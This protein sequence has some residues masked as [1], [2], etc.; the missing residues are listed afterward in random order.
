MSRQILP[1]AIDATTAFIVLCAVSI[2]LSKTG[3]LRTRQDTELFKLERPT[4]SR[5]NLSL[6]EEVLQS[7]LRA[8]YPAIPKDAI[9][10]LPE[11]NEFRSSIAAYCARSQLR[12]EQSEELDHR[13]QKYNVWTTWAM[14]GVMLFNIVLRSLQEGRE[15]SPAE[16]HDDDHTT[17]VWPATLLK[18]ELH[19]NG[20][21]GEIT[22]RRVAIKMAWRLALVLY[23]LPQL[24]ILVF[25]ESSTGNGH[26]IAGW[27]LASTALFGLMMWKLASA[28]K[29]ALTQDGLWAPGKEGA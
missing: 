11:W 27:L 14:L 9:T 22:Y 18:K 7:R 10:S 28:L 3:S 2:V 29:T 13:L 15:E 5:E 25:F 16:R 6:Y 19:Q 21:R 26:V 1:Q 23:T 24:L 8:A 12:K 20:N 4:I 17:D